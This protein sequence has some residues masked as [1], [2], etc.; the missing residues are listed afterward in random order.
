MT[1]IDKP[2]STGSDDPGGI[3]ATEIQEAVEPLIEPL[4]DQVQALRKEVRRLRVQRDP[5]GLADKAEA[6]E[7]L[8]V[9]ERTVDTLIAAGEITSIKVRRCRRIPRRALRAYIRRK[10]DGESGRH[11]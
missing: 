2:I 10:A 7:L 9:S 3:D 8:G 6:A 1:S 4:A 11:G 5:E